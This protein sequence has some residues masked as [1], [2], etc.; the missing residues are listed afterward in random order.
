MAQSVIYGLGRYKIMSVDT[1]TGKLPNVHQPDQFDLC[2][3]H[4][5]NRHFQGKSI[6]FHLN[7]HIFLQPLGPKV[8][9]QT[10]RSGLYAQHCSTQSIKQN[11][12]YKIKDGLHE[13]G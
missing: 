13:L 8:E 1:A 3:Y 5:S 7:S 6:E 9:Y 11:E 10:C 4:S 2:Q 12:I